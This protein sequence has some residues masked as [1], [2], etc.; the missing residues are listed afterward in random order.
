[1]SF[2][3]PPVSA[4]IFDLDGVIVDSNPVH[5]EAWTLFNRRYGLET[6]SAM[7][8]RMYGKRNDEIVRDFFGGGLTAAEVAERGRE[9]ERLYREM[10]ATRVEDMLVPGLREFLDRFRYLPMAVASNAEPDNVDFLLDRA[11]LRR[12]FRAV[13]NGHEVS[14]PKPHPEVYLLAARL[15]GVPR[16]ECVVFEDSPAGV[17]AAAAAGMRIV[18]IRTTYM[19]LPETVL[20]VD[21]FCSRELHSWLRAH[22][23]PAP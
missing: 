12:Y 1:V 18:G 19:N 17:A 13:L 8:E 23:R 4:L 16:A 21:N 11:T 14:R 7:M 2:P 15:L 6:T 22:L 10:M 20:T 3:L 5:R 9:K